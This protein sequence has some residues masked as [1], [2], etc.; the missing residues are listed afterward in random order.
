MC[1]FINILK[2][3]YVTAGVGS[4]ATLIISIIVVFC[5]RSHRLRRAALYAA[6]SQQQHMMSHITTT[7]MQP[8]LTIN[9]SP[10]PN[11]SYTNLPPG[12]NPYP[13]PYPTMAMPPPKYDPSMMNNNNQKF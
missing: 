11:Y 6:S 13:Y 10:Q 2:G 12:S 1:L 4:F 8:P 9:L 7:H 5:I 3:I